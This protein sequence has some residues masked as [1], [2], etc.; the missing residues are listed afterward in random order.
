MKL[1]CGFVTLLFGAIVVSLVLQNFLLREEL[2][3]LRTKTGKLYDKVDRVGRAVDSIPPEPLP[4]YMNPFVGA[5]G[6]RGLLASRHK[7]RHRS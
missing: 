1:V 6:D 7:T 3:Q 5:I 2:K 4:V